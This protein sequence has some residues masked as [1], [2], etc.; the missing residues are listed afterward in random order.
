MGGMVEVC[1]TSNIV[2]NK[3]ASLLEHPINNFLREGLDITISTDDILLFENRLSDE[4]DLVCQSLDLGYDFVQKMTMDSLRHSF[5][6]ED[7]L[8][9]EI[10]ESITAG[11][12]SIL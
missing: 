11:Y 7:R 4:I 3:Y 8:R 10:S 6:R 5:L 9:R 12:D 2:T 1:P